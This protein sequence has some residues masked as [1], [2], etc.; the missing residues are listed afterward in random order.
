MFFMLLKEKEKNKNKKTQNDT[1]KRNKKG[2]NIGFVK[3]FNDPFIIDPFLNFNGSR[4]SILCE[5]FNN[6][7]G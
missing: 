7:I 5:T 3:D 2:V 4:R 1:H 6:K